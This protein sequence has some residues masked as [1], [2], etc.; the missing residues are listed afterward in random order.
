[1]RVTI[2]DKG[3]AR[4]NYGDDLFQKIVDECN[5]SRAYVFFTPDFRL[6]N[7]CARLI[8]P[9]EDGDRITANIVFLETP[10]SEPFKELVKTTDLRYFIMGH[11]RV[12]DDDTLE[13]YKF[14]GV[15][16]EP[17]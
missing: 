2:H 8:D 11:A 9:M 13:D 7:I 3:N 1:M 5:Q 17:E 6:E 15:G 10:K 12:V 14:I 16:F 4:Y